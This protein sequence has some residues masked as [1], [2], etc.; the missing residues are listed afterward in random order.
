MKFLHIS[1]IHLGKRPFG[2]S[3]TADHAHIL[4]QMLALAA[5]SD[6][7]AVIIAGDVYNRASPQPESITQFSEFLTALAALK[8]PVFIIRGNHDGEAQLAYAAPLLAEANIHV[9]EIFAGSAARFTLSDEYGPVHI[10][11]LPFIKPSQTRKFFPDERIE[12][13]ADAVSAVLSRIELDPA[14]RSVLVTHQYVLGA[15]T[16]DSEER[17]IGGVDQI[18]TAVFSPFDYVALGHLHKPQT[19]SQ[20][21]IRYCGSPLEF[22][23]DECGQTKSATLVTLGEKGAPN[24]F[25]FVPFEPLHPLR[26]I[27]GTLAQLCAQPR[28]ED[29]VQAHLTDETRPLDAIGTLKLTYPNLLNLTFAHNDAGE[30]VEEVRQ[31]EPSLSPLEHFIAFFTSQNG[32]PPSDAQVEIV[33]S[34]LQEGVHNE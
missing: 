1:D 4:D 9:S 12:T 30:D 33:R 10:Y 27:E 7:D 13:Y 34:I 5:R 15:Q 14:A 19:L 3:L 28:S 17:S 25:E 18:P 2:C 32:H 16:S 11:L 6:V 31:F 20:G 24:A 23:F 29:Y 8:K 26:R 21:R 22:T